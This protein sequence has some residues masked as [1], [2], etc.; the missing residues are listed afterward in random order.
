MLRVAVTNFVIGGKITFNKSI[1][2]FIA[3]INL[4]T[5][6]IAPS[7]KRSVNAVHLFDTAFPLS[8]IASNSSLTC[9]PSL[10]IILKIGSILEPSSPIN[11]AETAVAFC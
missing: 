5:K 4:S 10:V 2:P 1:I 9:L 6:T 11:L 7:L 8:V 3:G